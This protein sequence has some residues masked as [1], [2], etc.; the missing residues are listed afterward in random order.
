MPSERTPLLPRHPS[1]MDARDVRRQTAATLV[2]LVVLTLE[3]LAYYA[4]AT[5]FFL[6]LNK[7]P[8][9]GPQAWDSLDAM[10][11]VFVL[12]GVSYM[13]AL[14]GGYISDAWLGRFKTMVV[15][16]LLYISGYILLTLMAVDRL[17]RTICEG[18]D[19]LDADDDGPPN[20]PCRVTVYLSVTIVGLGVGIVK[21]NIA[22]FGAEQLN[23][24]NPQKTRS[25]FNWFYWCINLGS[26]VGVGA[27]TYIEQDNPG[28][29]VNGFFCGYLIS[30][31]CLLLALILF[32]MLLPCYHIVPPEGSVLGN[33]VK[34]IW[35]A[36]CAQ[37]R[38]WRYNRPNPSSSPLPLE[39]RFLDRAKV[40]FGGSFH[41]SA[42]D[43]VR[44]LGKLLNVFTA[45]IPY[46]LVY[47]QMETSF[48]AQGLHMRFSIHGTNHT[49]V[50][51]EELEEI[52]MKK[53][54][55]PAAWLTLF[56]QMFLIGAIPL[57]TSFLYPVMDR[58]G[59]RLSMLFRIG[60]GMVFSILAVMVAGGLESYRIFLWR[61]D[62]STHIEQIVGNV[63]YHAVDIS[64]FWQIPQY[65]LVGAAELFASIAGLEFAYAA[66]PRTFQGMIMG[67]FYTMEGIGSL[68][69]T[70]L[71][72]LVSPFWLNNMTDYGNIND[73]HL[74]FYL[75][76]LGILQFTTFL[77]YCGSLYMQRFSLRPIAMPRRRSSRGRR[78]NADSH[79]D[80]EQGGASLLKEEEEEEEDE[81]DDE[82]RVEEEDGG[83]EDA[84]PSDI[85]LL[86]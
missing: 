38:H 60:I 74:D 44:S 1:A 75:Y 50:T 36:F 6:F 68:L 64:I 67:L 63:T 11:A 25:F 83:K 61:T 13:S 7:G 53:F 24:P 9:N 3:R 58:A 85:Q 14:L 12:A 42:V 76:F 72:H 15:G 21:S 80:R 81:G 45:L 2:I 73:N 77:I 48:Q 51:E 65:V 10:N 62:N 56:N 33:I 82:D 4:L 47:F 46:W 17:P 31:V 40:R 86:L 70:A 41:E 29:C 84:R 78:H 32:I 79:T 37:I 57:L 49:N 5:N 34:I 19:N 59:I 20:A 71:L 26:L 54:N 30:S 39:P 69:G 16:F 22:P 28:I 35:E 55:V 23:T 52:K 27:I 43:D 18:N 8:W 66:A